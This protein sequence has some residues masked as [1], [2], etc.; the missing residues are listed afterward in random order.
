MDRERNR[1]IVITVIVGVAAL[2]LGCCLG[3]LGG[4]VVFGTL[5]A[6]PVLTETGW[7][8]PPAAELVPAPQ[9]PEIQVE[10]AAALIQAVTEDGPAER[11]GLQRGDMI[12]A[13]DERG[14]A[15]EE[16]LA[17][18][19]GS[20]DPGTRVTLSVLRG[21]RER[22]FTVRLGERPEGDG[23]GAWLGVEYRMIRVWQRAPLD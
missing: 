11:A 13:I 17:Q 12:L 2:L 20:Y 22:V 5:W 8:S 16:T 18:R 7:P 9:R 14:F 23:E 1:W 3:A 15:D 21:S 10:R 19:L 6:T 4:T